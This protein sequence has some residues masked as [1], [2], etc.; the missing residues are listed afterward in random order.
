M[1]TFDVRLHDDAHISRQHDY[2][3]GSMVHDP[4]SNVAT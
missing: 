1:G 4:Q 3:A 2:D